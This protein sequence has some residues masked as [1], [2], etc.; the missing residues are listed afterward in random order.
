MVGALAYALPHAVVQLPQSGRPEHRVGLAESLRIQIRRPFSGAS[1]AGRCGVA[2]G[3][4][5]ERA[6]E[7][8]VRSF[9]LFVR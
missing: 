2:N 7:R 4:S 1:G 3:P 8:A 6:D 5:G 9:L